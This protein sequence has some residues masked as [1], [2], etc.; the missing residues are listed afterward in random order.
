MNYKAF[1]NYIIRTPVLPYNQLEDILNNEE[2]LYKQWENPFIQ[3]AIY[4]ASPVLYKELKKFFNTTSK[5]E[6]DSKRLLISFGRYISRMSTRCTPFGL[7][8]GCTVGETG[9]KCKMEFQDSYKRVTRLDMHYLC[10]L[11]DELI[12]IPEIKNNIRY[13]PNSSLYHQGK[14]IRYIEVILIGKE[15]KYQLTEVEKSTYL[16][17]ILTLAKNGNKK[18]ILIQSL[19]ENEISP[20]D[21][22]SFIDQLIDCQLLV[23]EFFQA[24]TGEDLF[25]R[26]IH[27][28]ESI[29]LTLPLLNSLKNIQNLL[30]Q[31]DHSENNIEAYKQ[32]IQ[33]IRLLQ[34]PYEEKYLFQVD[35]IKEAKQITLSS[36]V[37]K[38]VEKVCRF[39]NRITPSYQKESLQQFK[40]EFLKRYEERKMPLMEV[41]DPDHGIGYPVNT[42]NKDISPFI[43]DLH[44]PELSHP[45]AYNLT[46]FQVILMKKTF[47]CF[48]KN[49]K[50]V[51]FSEED[52]DTLPP[53]IDNLPPTLYTNV[54]IIR[55]KKEDILLSF[56]FV[57]GHSGANL[58]ARFAHT[59]KKIAQLVEKIAQKEQ[60]WNPDSILAEIVHLPESR[61]GNILFRPHI[62]THEILFMGTSD[63]K[64][65]QCIY[66]ED[67]M[68]S[69]QN[70]QIVI[71]SKKL[72]KP[73][74]PRLTTAHNYNNNT[75]PAY[76]FLCD[77]QQFSG[78]GSLFSIGEQNLNKSFLFVRE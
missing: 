13:F 76:R 14:K 11:Y 69:V 49:E 47:K 77:M 37:I 12:K 74:I 33:E 42:N 75:L 2:L 52:L 20:D 16:N 23:G 1:P 56:N 61:V 38:E 18:N 65:E 45:S 31:I 54:E 46:P 21:A 44:L 71:H 72:D 9:E 58:L 34:I 27:L 53:A 4:I 70:D 67:L 30:F 26:L 62:H 15:K 40:R 59:D 57:S 22:N 41:L 51:L 68:L 25:N 64:E 55:G 39:L 50:E 29:P 36:E 28:V 17:K 10:T 3:E 43:D 5:Q 19:T 35:L 24:V 60:E 63:L 66:M 6:T 7:F 8:A 48:S 73:I 32:I 78:R